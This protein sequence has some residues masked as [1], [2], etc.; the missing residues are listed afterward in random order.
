MD[1]MAV[2]AVCFRLVPGKVM[3]RLVLWT[4]LQTVLISSSIVS[5]DGRHGIRLPPRR[6]T[7]YPLSLPTIR[8]QAYTELEFVNEHIPFRTSE[9]YYS[10]KTH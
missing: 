10:R 8:E 1:I 4:S 7:A 9:L 5:G 3:T 6:P 2:M